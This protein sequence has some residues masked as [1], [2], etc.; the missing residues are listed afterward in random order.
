MLP[1]LTLPASLAGLK[2]WA[3]TRGQPVGGAGLLAQ[4]VEPQFPDRAAEVTGAGFA[5]ILSVLG[6]L[7]GEE[8]GP[9]EVAVG[10]VSFAGR[11]KAP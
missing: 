9:A 6:E 1:G 7:A 4:Q 11:R 8:V 10:S 5:E 3:P 2:G